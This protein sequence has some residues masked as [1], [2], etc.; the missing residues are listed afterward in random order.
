MHLNYALGFGA[1]ILAPTMGP[2]NT[3]GADRRALAAG[4]GGREEL[5]AALLRPYLLRLADERG[6]EAVQDVLAEARIRRSEVDN[7]SA[8]VP[9]ASVLRALEAL[10]HRLGPGALATRGRWATHPDVLGIYVRLLRVATQPMDAY[11]HLAEYSSEYS[12]V[13]SYEVTLAEPSRSIL[14]YRPR[15]EGPDQSSQ[16]LCD[17]RRAELRSL[18]RLWGLPEAEL[19]EST[20]IARGDA[21]CTYE[22]RWRLR[23]RSSAVLGTVGGLA[24]AAALVALLGERVGGLLV[25][26]FIVAIG[27][28]WGGSLGLLLQ[29]MRTDRQ[30]RTLERHRIAA[31]EHGLDQRGHYV[32]SQG[33]LI[34]TVLGGK[35]RILRRI[36]SGGIGAVYAAE[37][38]A[39]GYQVAVKVLRGA[40]AADGAEIAR[41]R[42]EARVQVSIEHPNVVRTM[43]LD[44]MPDGSIYVVMELLQGMSLQE[45]LAEGGP[46]AP[47]FAIP[48]FLQV[49]RALSAAHRLGIVHRDLKPGNIFIGADQVVKVLDFGMSKLAEA[50]ALT[51][52]G[53]TLGTPEYMSPEQCI[54]A[55]VDPRSD[56]YA[57]G[58]LMYEA[59]TGELPLSGP[60][61]RDLLEMHQRAIP[62]PMRERRP[63]LDIP[64]E[65]DRIVMACLKKRA[66]ERPE[67]AHQL[68][69][70][71]ASIPPHALVYEYPDDTPRQGTERPSRRPSWRFSH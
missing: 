31:L 2:G 5:R 12:R 60:T 41:L 38:L 10:S 71:L 63:D 1:S 48:I 47:G 11:K 18:P 39:L 25:G 44:Q 67:S 22:V 20:C 17:M 23:R 9:V 66:A 35:Y 3:I 54:G 29:R 8:W 4:G 50:D 62:E 69:R 15:P 46:L 70:L 14:S 36:G 24:G 45:H 52:D 21:K 49:C 68:E 43:D 19:D 16:R 34:N 42:R 13:G 59:L 65:L 30:A 61:R 53:Y 33:A 32:D 51:Q 56:L 57:F 37:H 7:D 40:A 55:P 28:T 6:D 58:A 26:S 27:A 64:P